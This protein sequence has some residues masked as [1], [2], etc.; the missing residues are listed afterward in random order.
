M[1]K[2]L[3]LLEDNI[4]KLYGKFFANSVAGMA[5]IAFYILVDTMFIGRGVGSEGLAA[6]NIV[7][8]VF[9]LI[10]ATGLLIGIGGATAF[11]VSL[12]QGDRRMAKKI[13]TL[14]M[15]LALGSGIFYS[16]FGSIFVERLSFLLGATQ[17]SIV[18]VKEYFEIII[19]A[20]FSF[21]LVNVISAFVRNDKA[22]QFAMWVT[23]ASCVTNIL[24][25]YV[26]IFILN[27]GMRG[28]ALAT[29]ISSLQSLVI[30]ILYLYRGTDLLKFVKVKFEIPV[31]KRIVINGLSSFLIELSSGIVIFAFNITLL[32]HIGDIGIAAYSIVAN[33]SLVCVAVFTGV[34]Q[35]VQPLVSINYGAKKMPR[36]KKVR[37]LGLVSAIITGVLFYVSGSLFAEQI[38]DIFVRDSSQIMPLA[39]EAIRYYFI[40]FLFMGI[41]V[42]MGSYFQAMEKAY[43]AMTVSVARGLVF[44]LLGLVVLPYYFATV[45]IWLTVPFAEAL[46]LGVV[47]WLHRYQQSVCKY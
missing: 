12:G 39:T 20:A 11:S 27:M 46:S 33:I 41:N 4:Y 38:V 29:V 24:L 42:V 22:P 26:F 18:L 13:F 34:A 43:F 1:K 37:N 15:A 19:L 3:N 45:G 8:P 7:L 36:V 2:D 28:A 40:A 6:L 30:F 10:F 44:V 47:W 35:G 14:S 32:K 23:I 9:N 5:M 25:D 16:I 31:L 21:I 17:D